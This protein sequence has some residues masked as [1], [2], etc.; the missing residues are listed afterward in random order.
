MRQD[1]NNKIRIFCT[2]PG[3]TFRITRAI[4]ATDFCIRMQRKLEHTEITSYSPEY[5][6]RGPGGESVLS[7][8]RVYNEIPGK[9]LLP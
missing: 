9:E 1:D 3:N 4:I 5:E 2:R 6:A 8:S 7:C